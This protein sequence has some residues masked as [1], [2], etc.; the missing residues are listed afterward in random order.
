LLDKSNIK[1]YNTEAFEYPYFD[2]DGK[3][4]WGATAMILSEI[5]EILKEL[6]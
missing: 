4:I 2:F 3:K 6:D 1:W 5:L